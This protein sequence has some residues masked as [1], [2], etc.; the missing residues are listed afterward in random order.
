MILAVSSMF[1]TASASALFSTTTA[2]LGTVIIT[3]LGV[4]L[5]AWAG[6]LVLRF[7]LRKIR[8]VVR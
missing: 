2:S 1:S 6:F 5:G 8:G 3:V 4:V 7:A